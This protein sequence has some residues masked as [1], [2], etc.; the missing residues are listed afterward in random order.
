MNN[1][2]STPT[3]ALNGLRMR[4]NVNN[5]PPDLDLN[6]QKERTKK[7]TISFSF[8]VKQKSPSTEQIET[9]NENEIIPLNKS[10][11]VS[12]EELVVKDGDKIETSKSRVSFKGNLSKL[13]SIR[14]FNKIIYAFD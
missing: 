2:E 9:E 3:F 13:F 4:F 1:N 6:L 7:N 10:E 12:K 5:V 8:Q 11:E 14:Y